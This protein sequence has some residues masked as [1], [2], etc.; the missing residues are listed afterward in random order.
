MRLKDRVAI[1]TGGS[2][3]IGRA[4]S[5]G[6]AREGAKVV[7]AGRTRAT[8]DQV[9]AEIAA[10]GGAAMA[11]QADVASE[12]DVAAMVD[13]TM[14]RFGRIDILVNNAA[15]NMP[16][17]TVADMSLAD[18]NRI[19]SV[20]LTGTFLCCRAVV[21]QMT[22]QAFGKII[23]ISSRGGRIGQ[24]G[25]SPYRSSKAAIIIF[26]ECLAAEVQAHGIDV[27][28]VCPGAVKTDMMREITLG[29]VPAYAMEPEDIASV[30]VFL[31]SDESRAISGTAIDVF[32]A[33][34]PIYLVRSNIK[35]RAE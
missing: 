18:W 11:I 3:G 1:V 16:Y 23:N 33:G 12:A 20:N 19:V 32:G 35:P 28:A 30:V 29:S 31:A 26:T 5:L 13:A 15:V 34:N 2:R 9:V 22:A 24:A 8:C 7:V 21:P 27:N 17:Q 14:Q 25:R 6:L 4:I 10:A